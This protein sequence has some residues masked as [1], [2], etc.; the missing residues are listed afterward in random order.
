MDR[1]SSVLHNFRATASGVACE[2]HQGLKKL[3]L[4]P[5]ACYWFYLV[6]GEVK[7]TSN[8]GQTLRLERGDG[9]WLAVGQ[10]LSL[11]VIGESARLLECDFS[12]G[13]VLANNRLNP[14]L[15]RQQSWIKVAKN[16]DIAK[17]LAPMTQLLLQES[18]D[19]RCGSKVVV[20]RLAEAYLVQLL[21]AFLQFQRIEVGL[22]AG[23]SDRKLARALVAIHDDPAHPWQVASLAAEAG[24]SR[25]V[26]SAHFKQAMLMTPMHYLAL[27]RMRLA[28]QRLINGERNLA[29]LSQELGYQSEAAFRRT[30]KKVI[31]TTPGGLV[32]SVA[33]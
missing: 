25:S 17:Q 11:Q 16:D 19:P 12:F 22:M 4:L 1:L 8:S 32:K 7:L 10:P 24:M 23:L 21:R 27:W 26:F 28:S 9:L 31:G 14:L 30:F 20:E 2:Q 33:A 6:E 13:S 5:H 29:L 3:A 15:E 18:M